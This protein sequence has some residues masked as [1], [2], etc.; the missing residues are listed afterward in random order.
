MTT[1]IRSNAQGTVNRGQVRKLVEAGKVEA[2]VSYH[3]ANNEVTTDS[4]WMPARIKADYGNFFDG[5]ANFDADDFANGGARA[6]IDDKGRL[7]LRIHSNLVWE[8]RVVDGAAD[9][10]LAR[11]EA[12]AARLNAQGDFLS[13]MGVAS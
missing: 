7:L 1:I 4:A 10:A 5:H 3:Y 13:W 12:R 6:Y 11:V 8:L 2:R 9:R